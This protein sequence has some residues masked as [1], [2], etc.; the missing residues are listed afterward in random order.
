[1]LIQFDKIKP[2]NTFQNSFGDD[3][4]L[5]EYQ[6]S[7]KEDIYKAWCEYDNIMFQ[8]PTGTGKTLL[9]SS[10][11]KDLH[12]YGAERKKPVKILILAHRKELIEQ[13]SKSIGQKYDI[14]HG[15]IQSGHSEERFYPI[16]V[17][18]VQTLSRQKRLDRWADKGFDIIIIDEAHRVL[19]ETYKRICN[20]YPNAK[21][22]GV[23]AT[24][25]RLNA[26]PFPPMFD[27]LICS[28]TIK[29]FIKEGHLSEYK[30]YSIKPNSQ[31]QRQINEMKIDRISG[32]YSD[33][34]MLEILDNKKVRAS[35][36]ETYQKFADG[37]KGIVYTISRAHNEHV[38]ETFIDAG[39]TAEAID[40][41]TPTEERAEI[42][43]KF[44][45]GDIQILCNV[46]IF[47][48]GFDCPDVEFV[49]LARPTISLAM[50]L[51]QV[52]RGFRPHESKSHVIFLDN[53][54]Q[55]NRF[56]LPSVNRR[57]Q[58]YFEGKHKGIE[59]EDIENSEIER[60]VRAVEEGMED[61]VLIHSSI[62][63]AEEINEE[64][65]VFEEDEVENDSDY[66]ESGGNEEIM[67]FI[68]VLRTELVNLRGTN[69]IPIPKDFSFTFNY[70][71]TEDAFG[72]EYE[73][74][75]KVNEEVETI[76][77]ELESIEQKIN[78]FK[79]FNVDMPTELQ[80][81]HNEL[82]N[83]I[84]S[85]FLVEFENS[86]IFEGYSFQAD[87]SVTFSYDA[88]TN[89]FEFSDVEIFEKEQEA[90]DDV[91]FENH[92]ISK[93]EVKNEYDGISYG[94]NTGVSIS[95]KPIFDKNTLKGIEI[96]G[97]PTENDKKLGVAY[98]K[99]I[100][101]VGK[102]KDVAKFF[103]KQIFHFEGC[104]FL[105]TINYV[106]RTKVE[107]GYR[108]SVYSIAKAFYEASNN[109][110]VVSAIKK[111]E[112]KR[113]EKTK[114]NIKAKEGLKRRETERH[115]KPAVRRVK[116]LAI[117]R[118]EMSER[119]FEKIILEREEKKAR[120]TTREI[121]RERGINSAKTIAESEI[122]LRIKKAML[123]VIKEYDSVERVKKASQR[124]EITKKTE[125]KIKVEKTA[126][127]IEKMV[128]SRAM[129]EA[130][131]EEGRIIKEKAKGLT[132]S[133]FE[134]K[135]Q[136][137]PTRLKIIAE[138]EMKKLKSEINYG[139]PN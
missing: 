51:Q 38:C 13:I 56:G 48:E 10:I 14:A 135:L 9:F 80:D 70:D 77:K 45:N 86:T 89:D 53:V 71:S 136:I 50:Y 129:K 44:K 131:Q 22:L 83:K 27:K 125:K 127:E 35:I 96:F 7:A 137:L 100:E 91:E 123:E 47:S 81:K 97:L 130:T 69:E 12:L 32:D 58:Y 63:V 37:K 34:A 17:A 109:P 55:F 122:D 93:E 107:K 79:E 43:R 8:M 132:A 64:D 112:I 82:S 3:I 78:V 72:I 62:E 33:Q 2:L 40:C 75:E 23:T 128:I 106:E 36:L 20:T 57:W 103:N 39:Y 24:P 49:Q 76:T 118:A 42:V 104:H 101:I 15:K 28:K 41:E 139:G 113:K 16:H 92:E 121:I 19:A 115:K 105:T 110:E 4:K 68:E 26:E 21:L 133:T 102:N 60:E 94:E 84:I 126:E 114:T 90:E 111:A 85:F 65:D 18:S 138:Q 74:L 11:I 30:Y 108:Y 59:F 98:K 52:G 61:V 29:Q 119:N 31:M 99:F 46:N 88:S 117:A 67:D 54:G 73:E 5:R 95:E 25:Y 87:F 134:Q 66:D 116:S 124:K 1:M 120:E 6:V